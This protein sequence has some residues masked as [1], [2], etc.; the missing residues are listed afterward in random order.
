M[1]SSE[2]ND[3]S[4][5]EQFVIEHKGTE[6]PF[7]GEYDAFYETGTYIC[8]R[9]NT[10][11]YTSEGKFDAHCGWPAFDKEV[12]GTVKR[13]PDPDGTRVEILCANCDGHLGHVFSGEQ[14]T[15]TNTRHC[16]NSL[17]IKFIKSE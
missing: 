14:L 4:A 3:L 9:C 17:S 5:Q 8:R 7:T 16:V 12:T 1:D 2:Y 11:L 15:P 10:E 6:P 13:L